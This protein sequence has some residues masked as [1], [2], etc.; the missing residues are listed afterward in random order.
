MISNEFISNE[1]TWL[2]V[3]RKISYIVVIDAQ[4]ATR[5]P[6]YSELF[7]QQY[8]LHLNSDLHLNL[9]DLL[10]FLSCFDYFI[11]SDVQFSAVLTIPYK[12][13]IQ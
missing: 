4:K 13:I 8:D 10:Q 1:A 9:L 5:S 11:N 3:K 6:P 7:L 12:R 2:L